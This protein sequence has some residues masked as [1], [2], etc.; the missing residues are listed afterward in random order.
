MRAMIQFFAR[1]YPA[2]W[3]KRYGAEFDALLEDASPSPKQALNVL[4]GA[5]EM[6]V[7]SWSFDRIT[8]VCALAGVALAAT[9]SLVLPSHDV[10]ESHVVIAIVPGDTK[11]VRDNMEQIILSG[12]ALASIIQEQG[13]YPRERSRISM[14]E[15][16]KKMRGDITIETPPPRTAF[17]G[18][19]VGPPPLS[20]VTLKFKYADPLVAQQVDGELTG[21]FIEGDLKM[22]EAATI[23]MPRMNFM[24]TDAPT[25]PPS[26]AGPKR[27]KFAGGGLLAGLLA[28]VTLAAVVR[29]QRK[30]AVANCL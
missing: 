29:F 14:D 16:V 20:F 4:M 10:Y 1:L 27:I 24:V 19:P 13:L 15:V 6:Q 8:L 21:R 25:L 2:R 18:L 28:G 9:A 7:T 3:R 26:L 17:P 30:R 12:P 5:I 22:R 11:F 23:A